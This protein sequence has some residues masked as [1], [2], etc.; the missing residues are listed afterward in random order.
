[1]GAAKSPPH[2]T[3]EKNAMLRANPEAR[4]N[5]NPRQCSALSEPS[6]MKMKSIVI[7]AAVLGGLLSTTSFANVIVATNPVSSSVKFEAPVPVRVV[8]PTGLF[9]HH[10]GA[11]VRLSLTV[12]ATGRPHDIRIVSGWDQN[13]KERL[14]LAVAQWRF[15]PAM[16]NGAP[17]ST[18][19]LLPVQLVDGPV[20]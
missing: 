15:K 8:N 19:I 3:D 4:I 11:I 6:S 16:K 18:K 12:D 14:L 20:S 5:K 1:M 2:R 7:A 17:V 9:R 10:E 13:L